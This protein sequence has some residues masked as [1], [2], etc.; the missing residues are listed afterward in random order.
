MSTS[1]PDGRRQKVTD[2]SK[3]VRLHQKVS[4]TVVSAD[5]DRNRI[6]LRLN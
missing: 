3:L 1:G 4:V 5:L 2:P 6:G